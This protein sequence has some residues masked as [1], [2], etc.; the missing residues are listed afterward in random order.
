MALTH[1]HWRQGWGSRQIKF[2]KNSDNILFKRTGVAYSLGLTNRAT[3]TMYKYRTKSQEKVGKAAIYDLLLSFL[4][5]FT[6]SK[7]QMTQDATIYLTELD[8]ETWSAPF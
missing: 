8:V 5:C 1:S 6:T 3:E 2:L 4:L 7:Y